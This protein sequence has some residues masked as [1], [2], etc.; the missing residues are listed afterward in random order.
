MSILIYYYYKNL[1][2]C[3]KHLFLLT[4]TIELIPKLKHKLHSQIGKVFK[5]IISLSFFTTCI[6]LNH[7]WFTPNLLFNKV[8][9]T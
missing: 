3:Y 6:N 1:G 8:V 7:S 2:F 9:I 5:N 4:N